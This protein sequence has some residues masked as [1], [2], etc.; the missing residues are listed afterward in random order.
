MFNFLIT[1]FLKVFCHSRIFFVI[2][3][4]AGIQ[5]VSQDYN[6]FLILMI[7]HLDPRIHGDDNGVFKNLKI[8]KF[9]NSLNL[10][11]LYH[12]LLFNHKRFPSGNS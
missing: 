3:A 5:F 4:E 8:I 11:Q 2:P 9:K 7:F 12:M 6:I 1:K 10:T